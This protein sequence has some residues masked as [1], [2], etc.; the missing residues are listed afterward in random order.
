MS[1]T[2]NKEYLVSLLTVWL[3]SVVHNT[4]QYTDY[5]DKVIVERALSLLT[6]NNVCIY[7]DDTDI[8][9][10]LTRNLNSSFNHTIYLKQEKANK[11]LNLT[12]LVKVIPASKQEHILCQVV[13]SLQVYSVEGNQ[14]Y[15][16]VAY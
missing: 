11:M 3:I 6:E 5:A 9:V 2:S 16:K 8:L 7:A 4:T 12:S 10:L 14:G 13:T 15:L 1:N